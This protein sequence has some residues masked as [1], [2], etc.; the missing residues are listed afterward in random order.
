MRATWMGLIREANI[1]GPSASAVGCR[2]C[3]CRNPVNAMMESQAKGLDA[4]VDR[5]LCA[6]PTLEVFEIQLAQ[7]RLKPVLQQ[8]YASSRPDPSNKV[9][10]TISEPE[11][12]R[13]KN[14]SKY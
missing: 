6:L 2:A 7:E 10:S 1:L 11:S 5:G 14:L 12:L 8:F 3:P 4:N 9:P 13:Q